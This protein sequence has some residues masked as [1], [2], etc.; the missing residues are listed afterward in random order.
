MHDINLIRKNP[1]QFVAEMERRF[2]KIDINEILNLDKDKRSIIFE[3]QELQNKRNSS[4]KAIAKIKN[5]KQ[6]VD[7]M[8]NRVNEIKIDMKKKEEQLLKVSNKL[9]LILLNL[10]NCASPKVPTGKDDTGRSAVWVLYRE[11]LF[12]GKTTQNPN[13]KH[14]KA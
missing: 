10:P 1:N 5:N 12:Q 8:I 4:S 7:K 13:Q 9:D 14:G 3:L 2:V 11:W 6:E